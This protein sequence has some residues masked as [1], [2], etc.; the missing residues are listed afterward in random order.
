MRSGDRLRVAAPGRR[1]EPRLVGVL[2]LDRH[3]HAEHA[4]AVGLGLGHQGHGRGAVQAPQRGQEGPLVVERPELVVDEQAVAPLAGAPLQ[5]QGDQVAEAAGR[6]GVLAREQPVVG[7]EP[8][9]GPALHGR[10][11]QRGAELAR[12]ARGDGPGEEDPDVPAL[13]RAGALEG[14]RDVPE[15]TCFKV[16]ERVARP[17]LAVEV[18]REEAAGLVR[19]QGIDAG[20]EVP[21]SAAP[22]PHAVLAAQVGLDDTVRDRDEG[23]ARALAAPHPRL[24]ADA[25]DPLVGAGRGV[26]GA[27]GP[28]VLPAHREHVRPAREQVPEQGHL[29]RRRRGRGDA[30][31]LAG[32][33]R[34]R[35]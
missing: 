4:G 31:P 1:Q 30:A 28:G 22:R 12:L 14:G 10:G 11:E 17:V 27:P 35:G 5:R 6:H 19:Q 23:L 16:G 33:C 34:R 26:A 25:G 15:T 8:D 7:G 20:H 18:G 21:G 24:A 2:V 3:P 9:L 13:A 29:R 32:G